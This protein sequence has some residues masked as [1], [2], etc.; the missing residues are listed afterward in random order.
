MQGLGKLLSS[1]SID[2]NIVDGIILLI[3]EIVVVALVLAAIILIGEAAA[4]AA[5][6]A[7]FAF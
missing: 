7:V 4:A 3:G 2:P 1:L 5:G 6:F